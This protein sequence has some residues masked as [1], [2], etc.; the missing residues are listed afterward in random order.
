MSNQM[1]DSQELQDLAALKQLHSGKGIAAII[2][3]IISLIGCLGPISFICGVIAII[4][5]GIARK[6]SRKTT[7]TAGMVMG[8]IGV[9]IS[10][11]ATLV[12]ILMFAGTMVPSYM[13]YA[14]KVEISQDTMVCDTVRSAITASI[15]DPAIVTDPDSQYFMESFCDGYYYDVEVF[16]SEDCALTDSVK[17]LLGVNSYDE[18]MEQIHSEDAYAMEF[19]VEDNTYVVVRLAGTDIE[20][21]NH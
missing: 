20:V 6:K 13:K 9:L 1:A 16:F 12:V 14:D 4:V 2:L 21:G 11:V 3:G 19:A 10:L 17:S 15:L 7:G 5:G 8:I 18:L